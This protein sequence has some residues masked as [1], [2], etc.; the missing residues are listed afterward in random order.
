VVPGEAFDLDAMMACAGTLLARYKLPK[1]V[2]VVESIGRTPVG[3]VDYSW[4]RSTAVASRVVG[5]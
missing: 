2:I 1:D 5:A 4:A 3:K